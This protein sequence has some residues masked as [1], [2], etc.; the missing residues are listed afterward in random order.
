MEMSR[1]EQI[2]SSSRN[3]DVFYLGSYVWIE[4]LDRADETA[5][6]T[7]L[8]TLERDVVPVSMLFEI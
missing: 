3:I 1:A 4:K 5:E 6:I 7:N 8:E 2:V